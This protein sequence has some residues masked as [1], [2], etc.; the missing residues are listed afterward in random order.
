MDSEAGFLF[1]GKKFHFMTNK[2]NLGKRV[3]NQNPDMYNTQEPECVL[4]FNMDW[5][6]LVNF[7]PRFWLGIKY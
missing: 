5:R 2:K 6:I 1:L 7:I 3:K 4:R